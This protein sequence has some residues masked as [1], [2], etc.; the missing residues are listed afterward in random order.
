MDK[1]IYVFLGVCTVAVLWFFNMLM[2]AINTLV[3]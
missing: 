1:L 2:W 3:I